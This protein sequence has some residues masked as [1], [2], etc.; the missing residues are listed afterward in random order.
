MREIREDIDLEFPRFSRRLGNGESFIVLGI[1]LL[2]LSQ[3]ASAKAKGER[4]FP[5]FS[6]PLWIN[7]SVPYH[8]GRYD[9]VWHSAAGKCDIAKALVAKEGLPN[10]KAVIILGERA[11]RHRWSSTGAIIAKGDVRGIALVARL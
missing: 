8:Q 11:V 3:A 7:I 6:R 4:M 10:E 1:G 2:R 5:L 9:R